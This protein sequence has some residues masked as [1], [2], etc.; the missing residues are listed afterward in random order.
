MTQLPLSRQRIAGDAREAAV[1][2]DDGLTD[3]QRAFCDKLLAGAKSPTEAARATGCEGEYAS[4]YASRTL[5]NRSVQEY[6]RRSVGAQLS[7]GAV[8][9]FAVMTGL[10]DHRSGQVQFWA[11]RD[12]LDRAGCSQAPAAQPVAVHV[13][14]DLS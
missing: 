10:L 8:R 12:L 13:T 14:I 7:V 11:A 6:L 5:R 1:P 9:A 2:D 3:K 4:V